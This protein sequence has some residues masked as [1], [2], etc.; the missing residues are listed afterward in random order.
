MFR[1]VLWSNVIP[2]SHIPPSLLLEIKKENNK[3][4][5]QHLQYFDG[6]KQEMKKIQSWVKE[7]CLS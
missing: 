6:I 5:K 7:Q 4:Q 1:M 3:K 2:K